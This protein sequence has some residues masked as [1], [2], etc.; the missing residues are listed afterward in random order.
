MF[1]CSHSPA[2]S[3]SSMVKNARRGRKRAERE[4]EPLRMATRLFFLVVLKGLHHESLWNDE[5]K[6]ED[7]RCHSVWRANGTDFPSRE[8]E[9]TIPR[10]AMLKTSLPCPWLLI[11]PEKQR[12]KDIGLLNRFLHKN[13]TARAK[14]REEKNVDRTRRISILFQTDYHHKAKRIPDRIP[15]NNTLEGHGSV[16]KQSL[17]ECMPWKLFRLCPNIAYPPGSICIVASEKRSTVRAICF[18]HSFIAHLRSAWWKWSRKTLLISEMVTL[19]ARC[20]EW[21]TS[22]KPWRGVQHVEGEGMEKRNA[23]I[24]SVSSLFTPRSDETMM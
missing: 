11:H 20:R 8:A 3:F 18:I 4:G 6:A 19:R 22:E 24:G 2:T 5:L 13:D 1:N 16:H 21:Q 9:Q 14:K 17:L 7:S 23:I 10:R 15:S 12:N